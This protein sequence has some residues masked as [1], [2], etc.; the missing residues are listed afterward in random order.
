[1]FSSKIAPLDGVDRQ[2]GA[3]DTDGAL[4]GDV[5]ANPAGA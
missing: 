1:M 4:L 3:I 2:A 5:R